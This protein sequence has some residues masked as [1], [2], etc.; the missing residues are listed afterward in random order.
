LDLLDRLNPRIEELSEAIERE[1]VQGP[2]VKRLMTHPG[3][4][5]LTALAFDHR[6]SGAVP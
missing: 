5:P 6:V 2:E 3:M 4:G 1:A